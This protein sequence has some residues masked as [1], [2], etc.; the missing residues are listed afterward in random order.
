M[1]ETAIIE[2]RLN[3]AL[4]RWQLWPDH[5]GLQEAPTVINRLFAEF[6]SVSNPNNGIMIVE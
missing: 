5:L 6:L 3:E 2:Q 1:E 4:A